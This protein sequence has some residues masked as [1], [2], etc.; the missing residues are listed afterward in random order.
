MKTQQMNLGT[1]N[2]QPVIIDSNHFN[3]KEMPPKSPQLHPQQMGGQA[4]S[5]YKN[6]KF[7]KI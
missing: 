6:Q 4:G 5:N 1:M 7:S 3:Q 2:I